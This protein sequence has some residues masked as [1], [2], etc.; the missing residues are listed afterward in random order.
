MNI[1][2]ITYFF[3]GFMVFEIPTVS[4]FGHC[5][6]SVIFHIGELVDIKLLYYYLLKAYIYLFII[7]YIHAC[8]KHNIIVYFQTLY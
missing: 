7:Q 8:F 2:F 3:V 1:V 5:P 6:Y 4:V